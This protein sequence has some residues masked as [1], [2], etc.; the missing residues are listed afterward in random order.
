MGSQF[1]VKSPY[2][3]EKAI[4]NEKSR[5]KKI[6]LVDNSSWNIYN[7]RLPL[8]KKLIQQGHEVVVIS[9]I[10]EF[11]HYIHK[12][13][14]I[15]HLPSKH[16]HPRSKNPFRDLLLFISLFFVYRREKPDLIFHF[17]IK[18][19]IFGSLA[20]R[21]AKVRSVS[22]V[23]GLGYTFLHPKGLNRIIPRLYK[24]A[25]KGIEKLVTYNTD[26]QADFVNK[27]IVPTEKCLIIPGSGVNTN[28]FKPIPKPEDNR[29]FI[30]LFIGRLLYDKGL[31]E[32][33]DAAI[34]LKQNYRNV[35]CW[36]AGDLHD[37]NPSGVPTEKLLHWIETQHIRY[38]GRVMD[39]RNIVAT[40]DVVVLPSYREGVPRVMLEALSMGKP[41]ITTDTAGCR[42]TVVHGLNGYLVPAK[43]V[44]A[45]TLAMSAMMDAPEA[46][47]EQMGIESRKRALNLFDKK[48]VTDVYMSLLDE[49]FKNEKRKKPRPTGQK[50]F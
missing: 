17:T 49:L 6:L 40:A 45:L 3:R 22:V 24:F 14:F 29:K 8:V 4:V 26:D 36:L 30:F 46:V 25:F 2:L 15:R 39:V 11:I 35:E 23:T 13:V 37:A 7:F 16:L 5:K 9:P 47:L 27:R 31:Q 19:N 10:D 1:F 20:A 38:L 32:Y 44:D 42:E 50:V 41:V 21:L 33:V 43:N 18:P 28:H 34:G 48:I 12:F